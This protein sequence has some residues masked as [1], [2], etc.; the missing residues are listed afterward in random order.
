MKK[1]LNKYFTVSLEK[2]SNDTTK[3]IEKIKEERWVDSS[4]IIVN[5]SP[6]Y[7][8]RLC[9]EINHKLSYLNSN[10]LYEQ[11]SLEMPYP[12]TNQIYD[13]YSHGY[14]LFDR[15]LG[16]W[17]TNNI[18][19]NC[20]YL[21]INSST[22]RGKNFNKVRL[23]VRQHLEPDNYRF[24]SL[25]VQ[26]SSIFQPHYYVEEF[27]KEKQGGL[28]FHWENIDNPNWDY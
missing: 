9:Q 3:L 11:I 2:E 5:C 17:I 4:T 20:K 26:S 1:I 18:I 14:Q 23:S 12:T 22:L 24:A 16:Q 10:E 8:S 6:D 19:N 13:P 27:D 15:Y 7:S 21:F 28:L 25:Y